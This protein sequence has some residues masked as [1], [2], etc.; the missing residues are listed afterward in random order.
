MSFKCNECNYMSKNSGHVN[1]HVK[2]V[3]LNIKDKKCDKCN[4][5]CFTNSDLK[6][7]MKQIHDGI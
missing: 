7:H 5:E 3:H 1:R 2:S 6:K 4:Y